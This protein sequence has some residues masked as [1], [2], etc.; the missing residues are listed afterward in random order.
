MAPSLLPWFY[1]VQRFALALLTLFIIS[2]T[3][4]FACQLL[5][6]D[7]AEILLGQ[8][9]TPE[10]VAGLRTAMGL[11]EPAI[12]QYVNWLTGFLQGDLGTSYANRIE[13]SELIGGRLVNSLKLAGITTMIS[14]PVALTLGILAAMYRGSALDRVISIFTISIISVPEFMLATFAVLVFAVWLGW[15]PALSLSSAEAQSWGELLKAYAMPVISLSIGVSAQMIR[16]T[17]AAVIET[18][19]TPYVE[20]ALLKGAS[21]SRMVLRHALPNAIGPIANAV[22]LSLS[23][24]VGGVIIVETIFNYPGVAKLMVDAV[25]TRDLPLIQSCAMIF[26]V[27]Y[28]SLITLADI[29]AILS[30]P[31]LRK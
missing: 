29:V 31:R 24:L 13:I 1:V 3:V 2:L 10:A 21:R 8:A 17:R 5:P 26:C 4:F 7:V 19:N 9:A 18:I 22:A 27:S 30:N 15:L 6:G 25:A 23:Y 14:V 16:M 20:M 28:L 11:D 12:Q